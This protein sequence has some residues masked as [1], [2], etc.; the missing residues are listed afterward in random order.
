MVVTSAL[1]RAWSALP[2]SKQYEQLEEIK[3]KSLAVLLVS[4]V[5]SDDRSCFILVLNLDS[6]GLYDD[7]YYHMLLLEHVCVSLS[8]G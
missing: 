1:V 8:S 7:I 5:Y 6:H 2:S 3:I 4:R